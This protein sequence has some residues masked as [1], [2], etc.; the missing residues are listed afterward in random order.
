MIKTIRIAYLTAGLLLLFSMGAAAATPPTYHFLTRVV[1]NFEA[2]AGEP[3]GVSFGVENK[4]SSLLSLDVSLPLNPAAYFSIDTV[5]STKDIPAGQTRGFFVHFK[6]PR[7]GSF[8]ALLMVTDGTLTDTLTITATVLPGQGDF[9]VH[10]LTTTRSTFVNTPVQIPISVQNLTD[11]DLTLQTIFYAHPSFTFSGTD[12]ITLPPYGS[13]VFLLDFLSS[14]D[15]EFQGR[16][17]VQNGN[18]SLETIFS[19][20]VT[21]R[22]YAWVVDPIYPNEVAIVGEADRFP[23]SVDNT[24]PTAVNLQVAL[25]GSSVFSMD[26]ADQAFTLDPGSGRDLHIGILS[27]SLGTFSTLI[28]VTD[29]VKTDSINLTARIIEGPGRFSIFASFVEANENQ[30]ATI[31]VRTSN[32]TGGS[33]DLLLTLSGD[34]HYSYNGVNPVTLGPNAR[35]DVAIDFAAAPPGVYFAMLHATDGVETDSI[36]LT[37]QVADEPD[38][39]KLSDPSQG[40]ATLESLTFEAHKDS[41]VTKQI[42]IENVSGDTLSLIVDIDDYD[43]DFAV[44]QTHLLLNANETASLD[45]SYTNR[46]KGSG[47]GNLYIT[48][49]TQQQ[50]ILLT[51][52]LINYNDVNGFRVVKSMK[53][54]AA[55][56]SDQDCEDLDLRNK[57]SENI[58][59]I[60]AVLSGFCSNFTMKNLPYPIILRGKYDYARLNICYNPTVPGAKDSEILTVTF[61]NPASNPRVQTLNVNLYGESRAPS[62]NYLPGNFVAMTARIDDQE[63]TTF[64]VKNWSATDITFETIQWKTGNEH[65]EFSLVTA[66]PLTLTGL[67]PAI[68]GSGTVNVTVQYAPTAQSSTVGTEDFAVFQLKSG[69]VNPPWISQVQLYGTPLPHSAP[70][71]QL[72]LFPKDRRT[73]EIDL[74]NVPLDATRSLQFM[75]NLQVAVTIS[76]FDFAG[77][78]FD[79]VNEGDFP[80]TIEPMESVTL[81]LRCVD[82]TSTPGREL[83]SARGSHE[84]LGSDF[85]VLS[86]TGTLGINDPA[87][88][89]RAVTLSLSPNPSRGNVT[90]QL[91]AP[92]QHASIV[93]VDMLGRMVAD[94]AIPRMQ[95][96]S[97]NGVHDGAAVPPGLYSVFIRGVD[98]DGRPVQLTNNVLIVR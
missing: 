21:T 29:G 97:W 8:S 51:G 80:V 94:V 56:T 20:F 12:S 27:T 32:E 62:S 79:I 49:R 76:G 58:M 30:P 2:T 17:T 23:F 15:G 68:P 7:T 92:L 89:P 71:S 44:S 90:M 65:G 3:I 4:G 53:F 6:S 83:G 70:E 16:L 50:K 55:D 9:S 64:A 72:L 47:G 74:G 84:T 48:G 46:G 57:S 73:Q 60:S 5:N 24:G 39:F 1:D 43:G 78:R 25:N 36:R 52:W 59:V 10:P 96:W 87:P 22:K 66:L 26:P 69:P 86:G 13:H 18:F 54:Y 19:V 82:A 63:Q 35:Q 75:N 67:N 91:S 37:V 88:A 14:A 98:S 93:I 45:V 34:S 31:S 28:T 77:S 81:E 95:T 61:D 11:T 33:I 41:T 85:A 42:L 40:P 38:F